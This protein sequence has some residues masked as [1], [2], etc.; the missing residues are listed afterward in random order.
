MRIHRETRAVGDMHGS[1]ARRD[2]WLQRDGCTP[3]SR[4]LISWASK[5]PRFPFTSLLLVALLPVRGRS[6]D[7]LRATVDQQTADPPRER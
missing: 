4:S 1:A 3:I 6:G 5:R 7:T 2:L